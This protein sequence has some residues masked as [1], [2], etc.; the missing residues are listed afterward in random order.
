[1]DGLAGAGIAVCLATMTASPPPWLSRAHPGDPARG[2][3]RPALL[4]RRP[5][6]LLPVQPAS[7]ASTPLRL[8]EQLAAPLRRP[9]GAAPCGTSATS[10]AATSA[11]ATATCRPPTSGA[12]CASGTAPSTRSTP[13]GRRPSGPRRTATSTRCCRRAPRR[14]SPTPP[15]S[16]TIARFSRRGS[17]RLLP[18]REGGAA[19]RVTPQFRSPPT[20]CRST[21][22]S[23]PS[24]GPPHMDVVALG[25]LPGPVRRRTTTSGRLSSTT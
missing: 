19:T 18:G 1:M 22:P 12:G 3:G 11:S 2:R 6:A 10:T 14:P 17:A 21:S 24:P 13:P 8:V 25:H 23:T 16:W 9:P 20:S 4:A 15:S 7:T 5:A